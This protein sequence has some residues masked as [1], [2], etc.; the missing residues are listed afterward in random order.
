MK[1]DIA[2]LVLTIAVLML[3]QSFALYLNSVVN[4]KYQG[5]KFWLFGSLLETSGTF[6]F[7]VR[8]IES[9]KILSIALANIIIIFGIVV[10]YFGIVRFLEQKENNKLIWSIFFSSIALL[11]FFTFGIDDISLRI[12]IA[13]ITISLLSFIILFALLKNIN[14]HIKTSVSFL[15]VIFAVYGGFF[16]LQEEFILFL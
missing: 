12:T 16:F 5:L 9:L 10:L 6:L 15:A 7:F 8:K 4:K 1:L 14:Q 11:L 13:S 3:L 2:T